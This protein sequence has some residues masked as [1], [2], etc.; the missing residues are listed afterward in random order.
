MKRHQIISNEGVFESR[1]YNGLVPIG[2]CSSFSQS[3]CDADIITD[4]V[5]QY[6]KLPVFRLFL[7]EKTASLLQFP[8]PV[9]IKLI[10]QGIHGN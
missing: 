8:M 10:K 6:P 2:A 7:T 5:I 4:T 9:F 3:N 1:L